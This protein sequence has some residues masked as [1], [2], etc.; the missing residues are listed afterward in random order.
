MSRFLFVLLFVLYIPAH[1]Q[2]K[3]AN[4]WY[5]GHY[6][7]LDFNAGSPAV[8]TDGAVRTNEGTSVASDADGKLLFYTDGVSVWNRRHRVMPGGTGLWGNESSTQSALIVP[9]PESRNIFYVF[10]TDAE[11]GLYTDTV[12]NCGCLSYSVVDLN[13]D[14]G[15]GAVVEKNTVLHPLMSEKITAVFQP[16]GRDVWVVTHELGSNAFRSYPVTAAGISKPVISRVG[17]VHIIIN[18]RAAAIGYMKLSPDGRKLALTTSSTYAEVFEFDAAS[19]MVRNLVRVYPHKEMPYNSSPIYGLEFSPNSRRLYASQYGRLYR[20]SVEQH[21]SVSISK[22][23]ELLFETNPYETQALCALQLGVDGRIYFAQVIRVENGFGPS[24]Y[25][26]VIKDPNRES[27]DADIEVRHI[28][29]EGRGCMVGLPNFNQSY[30]Y[31]DDPELEM[32]DVFTPNGDQW[33]DHFTSI[34]RKRVEKVLRVTVCNR[35]GQA[36]YQAN[37]LEGWDGGEAPAGIYYWQIGYEGI[38]GKTFQ[39]KGVVRLLR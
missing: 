36:V 11:G 20:M 18:N 37:H 30:L 16:N 7:G 3:E 6:A 39:A 33:N 32:P 9:R 13:A 22:S 29:L 28:Y 10:T 12:S 31:P 21:D 14:G 15:L 2:R 1:G 8:L 35:W 38:N 26:G 34:T 23:V 25:V 5:F 27:G 17:S 24:G 19:G 4:I